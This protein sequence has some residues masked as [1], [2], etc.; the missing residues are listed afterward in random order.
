[1]RKIVIITGQTA[2]GKTKLALQLAIKYNAELINC[3]SRQ[4]YKGLDIVTGKD[5]SKYSINNNQLSINNFNIGYYSFGQTRLWLYDIISPDQHFSSYDFVSCAKKAIEQITS[6][7]KIPIV[8]GGT[9]LYIKHLLDGFETEKIKPDWKTREILNKKTVDQL[10]QILK[11]LSKQEFEKMNHSDKNN[12]R[13]LI[14]KIEIV[15]NRGTCHVLPVGRQ[16]SRVT[17]NYRPIQFIGLKFSSREKLVETITNRVEKRLK[18][19]AVE[20]TGKILSQGYK[21]DDP[22][23]QSLGYKEIIQ[24]LEKKISLEEMREKWIQR[25]VSYAKRQYVFMKKDDRVEWRIV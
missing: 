23:L 21:I 20:E 18:N 12:P 4:I 10:Q 5:I 1:M 19:G 15:K 22:G 9:Y 2:T 3:D 24:Y 13:R 14:R 7:G 17:N 6:R 11:K 25:E 16:V 8:V